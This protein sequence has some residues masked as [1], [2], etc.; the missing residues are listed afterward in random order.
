V[1]GTVVSRD[2]P[3][4]QQPLILWMVMTTL[5]LATS[6]DYQQALMPRTSVLEVVLKHKSHINAQINHHSS[7]MESCMDGLPTLEQILAVL[8]TNS[9]S[10]MEMQPEKEWL[11][12]FLTK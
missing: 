10:P 11:F 8:A 5:R 7:W 6:M 2:A 3:Q 1:P 4:I 9:P 12:K